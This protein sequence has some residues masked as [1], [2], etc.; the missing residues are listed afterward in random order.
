MTLDVLPHITPLARHLRGLVVE[1]RP[2]D[3]ALFTIEKP[4]FFLVESLEICF[5]LLHHGLE[6]SLRQAG[7][8]RS[9][10]LFIFLQLAKLLFLENLGSLTFT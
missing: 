10:L 1:I 9:Q 4:V 2:V 6:M 8:V 3:A 5:M 7:I